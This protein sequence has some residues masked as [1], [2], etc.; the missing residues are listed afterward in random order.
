M[1][2]EY[3]VYQMKCL[4]S[5]FLWCKF[6][7]WKLCEKYYLAYTSFIPLRAAITKKSQRLL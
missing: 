5:Y 2:R 4:N 1:A 7:W 3:I 6:L